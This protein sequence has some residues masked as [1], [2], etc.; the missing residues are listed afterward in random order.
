[1]TSARITADDGKEIANHYQSI[2]VQLHFYRL[3]FR[4]P[5]S[6]AQTFQASAD[7]LNAAE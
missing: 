4:R 5:A 2:P 1:V 7:I 3:D 6:P